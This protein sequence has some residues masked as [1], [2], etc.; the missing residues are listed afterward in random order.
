VTRIRVVPSVKPVGWHTANVM[1]HPRNVSVMKAMKEPI[2]YLRKDVILPAVITVFVKTVNVC[3]T[4]VI[5]VLIVL[6]HCA[7]T[8]A[9]ITVDVMVIPNNVCVIPDGRVRRVKHIKRVDVL[10][11]VRLDVRIGRIKECSRKNQ[12]Q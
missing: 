3:V 10:L 7:N 1:P 2:V 9:V 11:I 8:R 6:N 4:V 5:W 12:R